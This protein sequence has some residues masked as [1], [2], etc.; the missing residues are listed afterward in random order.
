MIYEACMPM[1]KRN[2]SLRLSA[3]TSFAK[4]LQWQGIQERRVL[5]AW[6]QL[7]HRYSFDSFGIIERRAEIKL[8]QIGM[9]LDKEARVYIRPRE[10]LLK[11][12]KAKGITRLWL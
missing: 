6:E 12:F 10:N 9:G 4:W 7:A 2:I 5:S 8:I 11:I 3:N 1:T